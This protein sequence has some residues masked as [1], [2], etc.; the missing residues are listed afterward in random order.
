MNSDLQLA[1]QLKTL[2][3][4]VAELERRESVRFSGARVYNSGNI[5]VPNSIGTSLTFNSERFDTDAYHS[6]VSNTD[7]LTAPVAGTY[8]I[9]GTVRFESNATGV[10]Q[11]TVVLNSGSPIVFFLTDAVSANVTVLNV[12]T[13]YQLAAGDYIQLR[14]FQNSGGSLNVEAQTSY[15]PEFMIARLG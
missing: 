13:V 8:L 10:R 11:V 15:S 1:A 14:A 4:R 3:A 9:S 5:S 7:R 6:T 2:A 12:S